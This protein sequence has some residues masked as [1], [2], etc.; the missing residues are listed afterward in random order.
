MKKNYLLLVA[1]FAALCFNLQ[2]QDFD[3]GHDWNPTTEALIPATSGKFFQQNVYEYILNAGT[4]DEIIITA[5]G[6]ASAPKADNKSLY[7]QTTSTD[8]SFV[9]IGN[10]NGDGGNAAY[11]DVRITGPKVISSIQLNGTSGG[12]DKGSAA[13]L[14]FSGQS[15]F[16]DTKIVNYTTV[17]L[18]TCRAGN[19][20]VVIDNVPAGTKSFRIYNP[21]SIV[22]SG[23]GFALSKEGDAVIVVGGDPAQAFR[24]A[25][26]KL[27][28]GE[29]APATTPSIANIAGSNNQSPLLGNSISDIVYRWGGTANTANVTWTGGS[30]PAGITVTSDN[31][32]KTVTIAGTPTAAGTY[33]YSVT[34]TDGTQTTEPLTGTITVNA[35]TKPV[36]AF[37]ASATNPVDAG[38]IA[39]L[40]EL[41]KYYEVD[42]IVPSSS[43]PVSTFSVHEAILLSAVPSSDNVPTCLKGINK[44]LVTLKP[45]MF[46]SSRWN[47]GAP[48]NIHGAAFADVPSGIKIEDA[49]HQI[50]AGLGL[51]N[52]AE[53]PLATGTKHNNLRVLTPM[54]SWV[55]ENEANVIKLGTVPASVAYNYTVQS[56]GSG[57]DISGA[58]VIFEIRPNSV[59]SD[60]TTPVTIAQKT[61]HIG[62]SEQA[63]APADQSVSYLTPQLLTIVRNAVDYVRGAATSVKPSPNADRNL[64]GTRYF[65]ILGKEVPAASKGLIIRVHTFDNGSIEA[66]KVFIK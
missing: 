64:I 17:I 41:R 3:L 14:L 24:V 13:G 38:E 46:Q 30:I 42:V 47:W 58:A 48:S 52:G 11:F 66:E 1:V 60:G 15:D 4:D 9:Q 43:T 37:I 55:G 7:K 36:I 26:L 50:F 27:T 65:D 59:M 16:D 56:P 22:V 25:Y 31:D 63:F 12:T 62:V 21:A 44:P 49:S 23:D 6:G 20:G 33:S 8:I 54:F 35:P 32:A 18:A 34:A 2:A 5:G 45:F 39:I 28:L 19:E 29:G 61:I 51:T 40:T 57:N 10:T 53:V